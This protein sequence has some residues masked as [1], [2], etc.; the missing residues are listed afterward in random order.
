MYADVLLG[1]FPVE[2]NVYR[3]SIAYTVTFTRPPTAL[4]RRRVSALSTA[5]N[6]LGRMPACTPI[7]KVR[8]DAAFQQRRSFG[9]SA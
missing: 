1:M 6:E 4:I 5:S 2:S 3:L 8:V 9:E 7:S